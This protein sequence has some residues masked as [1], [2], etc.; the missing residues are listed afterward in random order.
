LLLT[1]ECKKLVDT[2][3][4]CNKLFDMVMVNVQKQTVPCA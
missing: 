2:I 3:A 4:H 1:M